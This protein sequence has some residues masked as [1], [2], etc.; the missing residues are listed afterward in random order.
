MDE[1][2]SIFDLYYREPPPPPPPKTIGYNSSVRSK[3]L[4]KRTKKI[5]DKMAEKGLPLTVTKISQHAGCSKSF[6]YKNKEIREY[7]N[8]FNQKPKVSKK[9]YTS[10]EKANKRIDELTKRN[11]DI[12]NACIKLLEELVDA[13]NKLS[14]LAELE[15]Q[16][17]EK[18]I[19]EYE[20]K[21][22]R[23]S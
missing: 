23:D 5:I 13:Y 17:M 7:I 12:E 21:E 15:I 10:L 18:E 4:V 8:S 3:A 16:N 11:L 22:W 20:K 14:L 1:N 9:V 2:Q 6:I 19:A